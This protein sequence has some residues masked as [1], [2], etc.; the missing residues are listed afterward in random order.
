MPIFVKSLG[1]WVHG[2]PKEVPS[3]KP[4]PAPKSP[5]GSATPD[6]T[7]AVRLF[8]QRCLQL[9]ALAETIKESLSAELAADVIATPTLKKG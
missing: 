3:P 7:A 6:T 2:W 4:A 5:T 9:A 1:I 8:T